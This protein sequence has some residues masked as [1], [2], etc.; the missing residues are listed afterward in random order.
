[1]YSNRILLRHRY[2]VK[3]IIYIYNYSYSKFFIE[4]SPSNKID[5]RKAIKQFLDVTRN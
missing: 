4:N 3:E 2:V 5:R 1:M